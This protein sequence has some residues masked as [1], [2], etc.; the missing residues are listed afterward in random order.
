MNLTNCTKLNF[1]LFKTHNLS[2]YEI[3]IW[4][5]LSILLNGGD[6]ILMILR[7][8]PEP[9]TNQV[10]LMCCPS[11]EW[12]LRSGWGGTG[13]G[14]AVAGL[15]GS[16]SKISCVW[17]F[18]ICSFQWVYTSPIAIAANS[19]VSLNSLHLLEE[20]LATMIRRA[21][22][23]IYLG[24][25]LHLSK[26]SIFSLSPTHSLSTTHCHPCLIYFSFRLI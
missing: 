23:Q 24:H 7:G 21:F 22:A 12:L 17:I 10:L 16:S 9:L 2:I 13:L 25:Q 26:S 1:A 15:N 19:E 5:L 14:S 3:K 18:A 4:K 11:A 8:L 20:Q 6:Q